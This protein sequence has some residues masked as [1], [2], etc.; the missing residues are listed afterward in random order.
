MGMDDRSWRGN[1]DRGRFARLFGDGENPLR[2]SLP[3]Y[4]A[5]GIA[6]RVHVVFVAMIVIELL[7]TIREDSIG[8]QF[9][10]VML[11]GLFLL[12]L[13]HEYGHCF[14]CRRVGGEADEILLWPLGGLAYCLPPNTWRA[15]LITTAGGPMVNVIL[16][17]VLAGGL[18]AAGAGWGLVF[19]DPLDVGGG[20]SEAMAL[21]FVGW[22]LW[23]LHFAN[24]LMLAFNLLVPMYPMDGARIVHAL[25]W[26]RM[27]RHEADRI[28][29]R[30][31]LIA[32]IVLGTLAL[33]VG[34]MLL[35]GIALF[36]GF[37]CYQE[38]QRSRFL[39]APDED[40]SM[41]FEPPRTRG[42]K[43]PPTVDPAE[44]DRILAKI[45]E[46]GIQSLTRGEKKKL[47]KASAK[48][49]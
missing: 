19:F 48:N 26:R 11:G 18:L 12:V 9:M 44:I 2:W 17:P 45:S 30:V 33:V 1:A 37:V 32:A 43:E 13:L 8:F 36:G 21:G 15:N 20:A 31:G 23:S 3:L 28:V 35:L 6:V 10:V 24:T 40:W 16:L 5:W 46:R 42:A 38:L 25:L 39:E 34:E 41:S 7:K 47:S 49:R 22:T 14:A 27:G 29:T 4:R